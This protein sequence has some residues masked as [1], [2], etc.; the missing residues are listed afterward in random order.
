MLKQGLYDE[1]DKQGVIFRPVLNYL[2][3]LKF[4]WFKGHSPQTT[5]ET[6]NEK[7]PGLKVITLS[8]IPM[9]V[10]VGDDTSPKGWVLSVCC[11]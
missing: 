8:A 11:V 1:L 3:H 2:L 9:R 6:S 7:V 5:E 10:Y 4:N